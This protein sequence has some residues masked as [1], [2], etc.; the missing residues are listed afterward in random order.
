M[1][2]HASRS[3]HVGVRS[4]PSAPTRAY[5]LIVSWWSMLVMP[6]TL[7]L[8]DMLRRWQERFVFTRRDVDL[9]PDRRGFLAYLFPYQPVI[10]VAALRGYAQHITGAARIW[11]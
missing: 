3:P 10:S 6:I 4:R 9:E 11:R 7:F 8:Y 5:P 2:V 1:G